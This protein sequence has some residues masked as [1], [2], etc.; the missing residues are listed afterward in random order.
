MRRF[1]FAFLVLLVYT[2]FAYAHEGEATPL[3]AV[4]PGAQT[5]NTGFEGRVVCDSQ[6]MSGAR[7]F[8]YLSFDDLVGLKPYKVSGPTADDGTYRMDLPA[9]KY[10][11]AVKKRQAGPDEGPLAP[12]DYFSFQG[13]NPITVVTG[14]YTHVGFA[15]VKLA[16]SVSYEDGTDPG[17]G[18]IAGKVTYGGEALQ[19]ANVVLYLDGKADFRGLGYSTAPP[20]SKEGSFRVDF[21]PESDY[22]LIARKRATGK[23]AGPLTDGDYFGYYVANPVAVKA[24]KIARITFGV[25]S[26][27]GEIGKDDSLFRDT[28]T[29]VTGHIKNK[30]GKPVKGV[31]A[32]AYKD[33]VMAHKRPEYI[34]RT[35]DEDGKYVLNLAEGAS[36]WREHSITRSQVIARNGVHIEKSL[37]GAWA[38]ALAQLDRATG[39]GHVDPA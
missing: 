3:P 39:A 29:H 23:A 1:L 17:T 24:G 30:D 38:A 12:G 37:P 34:S 36:T 14:R 21:L 13:S 20:T 32:F 11:L 8:A 19:G 6:V 5:P 35:V 4:K 2:S 15:L 33:K 16:Q 22:Y 18:S 27:A 7:V 31:Y 9:G 10:Y 28:G 26:K 25:V